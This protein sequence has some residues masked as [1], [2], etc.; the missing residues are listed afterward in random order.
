MSDD[1]LILY[2]LGGLGSDF[3]SLV[4]NLTSRDFITL[5]EVQFLLETHEMRLEQLAI[6]SLTNFSHPEAFK[7]DK[8]SGSVSTPFRGGHQAIFRGRSNFLG[9]GRSSPGG[10]HYSSFGENNKP[11]CQI[12]GKIGHMAMKCFHRFDVAF[13]HQSQFSR[14]SHTNLSSIPTPIFIF[15]FTIRH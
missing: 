3:E 6:A 13:Q 2:I 15:F 8:Q 7:S 9:R 4:V 11:H 10:R 14:N 5:E 12:C 1:E